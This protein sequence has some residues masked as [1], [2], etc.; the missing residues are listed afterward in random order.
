MM[1]SQFAALPSITELLNSFSVEILT[2][3][4]PRLASK[5]TSLEIGSV[6][7][8]QRAG[9]ATLLTNWAKYL[10]RGTQRF[11]FSFYY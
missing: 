2:V 6:S 8:S 5:A 3:M 11:Y 9:V 7:G 4:S 10:I 1:T